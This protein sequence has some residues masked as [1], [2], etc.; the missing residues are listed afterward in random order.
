MSDNTL[1]RR[2]PSSGYLEQQAAARLPNFV[3]DY[4]QGGS[5]RQCSLGRNMAAF[6]Q[7]TL[8]PRCFNDCQEVDLGT[9]LFGRHYRLPFGI[10]PIGLDGLIWPRTVE[11]LAQAA[12]QAGCPVTA[13]TFATS[14]LE[15]VARLAGEM[16]WFQ[17][18]PFSDGAIEQDIM[19]R[20]G[21][22]GYQ[23]L[24]VT[25]DVPVGGRRELDMRNGLSLPPRLGG[26]VLLDMMR[27][28]VWTLSHARRGP[29][30][31]KNLQPYRRHSNDYLPAKI[32]GR[33]PWA[34]LVQYRQ[35]WPGRLLVKG[36]LRA[37]DALRCRELG[38][39]GIVIS[40]HGGRQLDSCP[41][42]LG[43]LP[44]IRRAVGNDFP[45]IIDSGLRSGL[46]VARAIAQ[47]ADFA[48]L[49][50]TF[51]YGVAALG[52]VGAGHAIDMLSDELENAMQ[53]MGCPD[54]AGLKRWHTG[55]T[56]QSGYIKGAGE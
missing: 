56:A 21:A 47:G 43:V 50:R 44:D 10:A 22:A 35:R 20:A 34:R 1:M 2:F 19:A 46:D 52:Q 29:P 31:F 18:Y 11:F 51:M 13:S 33:V 38:I 32:A 27:H 23:V 4:L 42:T 5:G 54:I 48:L 3:F 37:E 30:G 14:S 15:E 26:R 17:L 28:P 8:T 12:R 7:V 36:V 24:M 49:G 55:S 16:A 40:N 39:D 41:S 45:L 6:E 53:M 9:T 25:V